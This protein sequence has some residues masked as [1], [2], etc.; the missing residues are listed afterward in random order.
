[1]CEPRPLIRLFTVAL[2]LASHVVRAQGY[3]LQQHEPTAAGEPF[4]AVRSP[5][6]GPDHAL[7]IG[8]TL[9]YG[10]NPLVGGR[11]DATGRF[12]RERTVISDQLLGHLDVAG[13]LFNRVQLSAS[14]PVTLLERGE[15]GF[16]VSPV[17]AVVV[18]DPR[19]GA[20]V[21]LWGEDRG[22]FGLHVGGD[23]WI[24]VGVED[25][26]AGDRAVRGALGVIADGR[27]TPN[28][29][30]AVNAGVTLRP[31]ASLTLTTS[32]PGTTGPAFQA[33]A[34]AAWTST[35]DVWRVGPELVFS[36]GLTEDAMTVASTRLEALMGGGWR[37]GGLVDVGPAVGVGI[38]RSAG[39][40]DFR[41]LLRVAVLPF[42]RSSGRESGES[43]RDDEET[44]NQ[45]EEAKSEE[46]A[47]DEDAANEDAAAEDAANEDGAD[48][49]TERSD[50]KDD[51]NVVESSPPVPTPAPSPDREAPAIAT[52]TFE[53]DS[54]RL[55][56]ASEV[57]LMRVLDY[58]RKNPEAHLHIDGHGD[59]RGPERWN[60][61]LSELRAKAVRRELVQRGVRAERLAI[62]SHGSRQPVADNAT[63]AGRALN[64]RVEVLSTR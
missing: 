23:L 11:V 57:E 19:I 14:L 42:G 48:D 61:T 13:V 63:A 47:A 7:A 40:P 3:Q 21:R 6:Y 33:G 18:G 29:I 26:H 9:N 50:D 10:H 56:P 53:S 4:F 52:L 55:T 39:T 43:A 5:Q 28:V 16:G 8:L 59:S 17:S 1:M 15:G 25:R 60:E 31:R 64:R 35:D 12:I 20:R 45:D 49:A 2:L 58:L 62:Q 41:A 51:E 32:G 44:S 38:S 36:T 34:A 24:P 30:W 27:A 37:I 46:V 54:D 22:A